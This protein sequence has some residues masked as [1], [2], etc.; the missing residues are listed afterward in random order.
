MIS[1]IQTIRF[2]TLRQLM[3]FQDSNDFHDCLRQMRDFT[4]ICNFQA[5]L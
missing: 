3:I 1:E 5:G 4:V 2:L